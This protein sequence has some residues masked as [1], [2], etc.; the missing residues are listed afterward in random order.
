MTEELQIPLERNRNFTGGRPVAA[1]G[2][3]TA[4][5]LDAERSLQIHT[6]DKSPNVYRYC[7]SSIALTFFKYSITPELFLSHIVCFIDCVF[8]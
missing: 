5:V 8:E 1:A 6:S 7:V 4:D 2:F 3:L